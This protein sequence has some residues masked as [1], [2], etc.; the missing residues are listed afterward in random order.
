MII[1]WSGDRLILE[2]RASE[3]YPCKTCTEGP[4]GAG[5]GILGVCVWGS[6]EI[7]KNV[8]GVNDVMPFES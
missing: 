4:R 1:D 7:F 5:V 3:R 8:F 2:H 6:P